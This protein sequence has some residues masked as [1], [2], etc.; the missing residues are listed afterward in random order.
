MDPQWL[1]TQLEELLR[2]ILRERECAK[3]F[4]MEEF[5]A[6]TRQKEALLSS[7]EGVQG[8]VPEVPEVRDLAEKVH[9]E[10]KRNA[11]L[12]WATLRFIRENVSFINRQV[13]Q[14]SYGAAGGLVN[15]TASGTFL[16]GKV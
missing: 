6:I 3:S 16:A 1:R 8:E 11:Y 7:I 10:N 4:A 13:T 2:L 5:N 12:F 9:K 14:T 15:K